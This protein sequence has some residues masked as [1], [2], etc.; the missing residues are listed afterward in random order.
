MVYPMD[1]VE[2]DKQSV[3]SHGSSKM[4]GKSK[5]PSQLTSTTNSSITNGNGKQIA[6]TLVRKLLFMIWSFA[7]LVLHVIYLAVLVSLYS[8][9]GMVIPVNAVSFSHAGPVIMEVWAMACYVV[10]DIALNDALSV[11]FGY[12]LTRPDGYSIVVCGFTPS[13]LIGKA[14]F[15]N[16]LSFRSSA[17]PLLAKASTI[18]ILNFLAVFL[19]LIASTTIKSS[20]SRVNKGALMC[21]EYS[22]ASKPFNRQIPTMVNAMGVAELVDP[23]ALGRYRISDPTLPYSTLLFSPQ[24]IDA[25]VDGTT[26]I[27]KGFQ[28]DFHTVCECS[29]SS[30]ASDLAAVRVNPSIVGNLSKILSSYKNEP[31]WANNVMYD[32]DRKVINITTGITGSHICGGFNTTMPAVPVCYTSVSNHFATNIWVQYKTDGTS[33]SIAAKDIKEHEGYTKKA[34]MSYLNTAMKSFFE[35][36][37][38]T[39][40]S[41]HALPAHWPGKLLSF[42]RDHFYMRPSA[43]S[44]KHRLHKPYSL[45]DFS[46]YARCFFRST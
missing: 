30:S 44:Y 22:Q 21:I 5:Q 29:V 18:F 6:D 20:T 32:S 35:T 16:R 38:D 3:H 23:N 17:K 26:I 7:A 10:T 15:P 4:T 33:A 8:N 14:R 46:K 1:N 28:A 45:D 27:G 34:N 36:T 40:I 11:F 41:S 42:F 13:G 2:I 12:L 9:S 43:N 31:A 39:D 19:A 37:S 25:A 24:L